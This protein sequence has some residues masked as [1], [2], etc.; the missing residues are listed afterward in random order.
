MN[1]IY[2]NGPTGDFV[3]NSFERLLAS[4]TQ[5]YL[6][7]PY[8]TESDVVRDAAS[9]GRQVQLIVGLNEATSPRALKQ[10]HGIPNL[11]TRFLTRR[12]HAKIYI[13]ENAAMVGSSNLTDGGLRANREATICLDQADDREAV[14]ELRTLFLELWH[15]AR[16]VTIET[17]E[18]FEHAHK[19]TRRIGPHPDAVIEQAVGRAEPANIDVESV[20][21]TSERL[22]IEQ[23]RR[24]VYEQYRP[25]FTQVTAI[26]NENGFHRPELE[27]VGAGNET[28]RFLNWVRLTKVVGDEAW[29]TAET[30]NEADRRDLITDLG[31]QWV[32]AP[33]HKIPETY[34]DWLENA[35][36]AF[37]SATAIDDASKNEL[38]EGLMSLH[39]FTEQYRFVKGGA[40]NLP[41]FF[42]KQNADDVG[43]VKASLTHFL[44]G[45]GEFVE[46]LHDIVYDPA[47]KL[48]Q[49]GLFCALE[50][51]GTVKPEECPPMNGRMAKAL[52]YLGFAVMAE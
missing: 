32:A 34:V 36:R 52:R 20:R 10:L 47:V 2:S 3:I 7:A 38:T 31:R 21:R 22:F 11:A 49:F 1:R 43:K 33:D 51:Y 41:A 18:A 26:L 48:R 4:S 15:A 44:H 39:A 45:S 30:R 13:F 28:N 8:F 29:R 46:R 17:L 16:V 14:E 40:I 24:Q 27:G 9:Q 5:L 23:L 37:G 12:F 35:T 6:A 19:A 50:L 42:W 25:A